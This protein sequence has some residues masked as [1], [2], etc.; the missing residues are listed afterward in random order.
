MRVVATG[1]RAWALALSGNEHEAR[2]LLNELI[3]SS[4]QGNTQA[5]FEMARVYISLNEF[6]N[7]F[8]CLERTFDQRAGTLFWLNVNPLFDPL[9]SDPRFECLL[10]RLNLASGQGQTKK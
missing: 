6:D 3:Q 8:A 9:R 2:Q 5:D 4:K 10:Q 7:A 1:G